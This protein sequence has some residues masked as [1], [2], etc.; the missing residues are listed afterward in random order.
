MLNTSPKMK[1]L[2]E[3]R[4][5]HA[6]C[7]IRRDVLDRDASEPKL[8]TLSN[9]SDDEDALLPITQSKALRRG[10]V[11]RNLKVSPFLEVRPDALPRF[12]GQF[13]AIVASGSTTS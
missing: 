5:G 9:R 12:V 1:L 8:F 11:N 13:L 10:G 6:Q 2:S 3:G 4:R 7:A